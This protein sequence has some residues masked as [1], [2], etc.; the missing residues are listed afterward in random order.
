MGRTGPKPNHRE[1][2]ED[3]TIAPGNPFPTSTLRSNTGTAPTWTAD[4][5]DK[6]GEDELSSIA[7]SPAG[8]ATDSEGDGDDPDPV[9]ELAVPHEPTASDT[10]ALTQRSYDTPA[11]PISG[12]T[13]GSTPGQGKKTTT[14][15]ATRRARKAQVGQLSGSTPEDKPGSI[16]SSLPFPLVH[17][18][19]IDRPDPKAPCPA[20]PAYH[21]EATSDRS[22]NRLPS[23]SSKSP[24]SG[25]DSTTSAE[26]PS[27][28]LTYPGPLD[29]LVIAMAR[30]PVRRRGRAV[31]HAPASSTSD[32]QPGPCSE[33]T[34]ADLMRYRSGQGPKSVPELEREAEGKVVDWGGMSVADAAWRK[35]AEQGGCTPL[36][37][38]GEEL[39][40]SQGSCEPPSSLTRDLIWLRHRFEAG[41]AR[42]GAAAARHCREPPTGDQGGRGE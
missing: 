17:H 14:T 4:A 10:H 39:Q 42:A 13:R 5:W 3:Q 18:R 31:V 24:S 28:P 12:S 19:A 41:H 25:I 32:T 34:R 20:E 16:I 37:A 40:D 38:S 8:T 6:E 1:N 2:K 36:T 30:A 21:L 7:S 26:R 33:L 23:E 35:Y 11:K 15:R 29:P 27:T 9:P 22:S